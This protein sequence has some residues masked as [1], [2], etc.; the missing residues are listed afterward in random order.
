M[1]SWWRWL[2]S[3]LTGVVPRWSVLT[4]IVGLIGLWLVDVS[5][6][7]AWPSNGFWQISAQQLEHVGMYL[8]VV[9]LIIGALKR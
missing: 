8:A 7:T 6:L 3:W 2:Q 1:S 5:S 9:M 4:G